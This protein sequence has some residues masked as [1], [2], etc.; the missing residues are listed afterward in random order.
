MHLIGRAAAVGAVV[1]AAVGLGASSASAYAI[2]GISTNPSSYTSASSSTHK[3]H[4]GGGMYSV[5]CSAVSYGGT[6]SGAYFTVFTPSFTGC[7]FLGFPATVTQSGTWSVGVTGDD[8]SGT[9]TGDFF[10][11]LLST[12][13]INVPL[14]GCTMTVTGGQ[15]FDNGVNGDVVTVQNYGSPNGVLMRVLAHGLVYTASGCPLSGGADGTYTTGGN[16]N[17]PGVMVS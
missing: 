9:Y 11:H 5:D 14:V 2:S 12:T 16:V 17:I 8:G 1:A 13:T 4:V 6:A 3:F 15:L 7:T 10:I